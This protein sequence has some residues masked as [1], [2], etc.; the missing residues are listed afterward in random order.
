[1]LKACTLAVLSAACL[2]AG[3]LAPTLLSP[4]ARLIPNRPTY[5]PVETVRSKP[6]SHVILI[7]VDG[8]RP[9]A[10][11]PERTPN[12]WAMAKG[13]AFA[14][15]ARNIV[16]PITIPNHTAMIT[17]L[18][19]EHHGEYYNGFQGPRRLAVP[20]IF[21]RAR[22]A[23]LSTAIYYGK[24][25]FLLFER[26]GSLDWGERRDGPDV[27]GDFARDYPSVKWNLAMLCFPDCDAAGH[28][29][30]WMGPQYLEAVRRVDGY[31]ALVAEAVR[32]AGL[33]KETH[34]L[35]TADHGG[36]GLN[37]GEDK[38]VNRTIPF[39]VAGPSVRPGLRLGS[40]SAPVR[41]LDM[42]PT[43][44][45]LLGLEPI[46]GVQGRVL[47]EAFRPS[48]SP[49]VPAP[50]PAAASAPAPTPAPTPAQVP[51][52]ATRPV[53]PATASAATPPT[54]AAKGTGTAAPR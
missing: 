50:E 2:L 8:L 42:T 4:V 36:E 7:A 22:R 12:I 53:E 32:A 20:T 17:G 48:E 10:L 14:P 45:W 3:C 9:D 26:A 30:G 52:L 39:L 19:A 24:D 21:D 1:M 28:A 18:D 34:I 38:P 35:L 5:P 13:G 47:A 49:V 27:A 40:E 16:P 54:T 33:E 29:Y 44:A 46:P 31:V 43:A 15:A 41:V 23:G 11:S 51:A 37:H 6:G 25:K